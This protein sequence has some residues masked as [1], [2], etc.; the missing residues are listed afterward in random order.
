MFGPSAPK[1][2]LTGGLSDMSGLGHP[3]GV[4]CRSVRF[5]SVSRSRF[6]QADEPDISPVSR[7]LA[8]RLRKRCSSHTRARCTWSGRCRRGLVASLCP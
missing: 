4:A 2:A 3:P 8:R 6:G 7:V 1:R 5:D